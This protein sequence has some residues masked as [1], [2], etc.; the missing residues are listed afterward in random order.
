MDS[1]AIGQLE[2]VVAKIFRR[3][4]VVLVG[5]RPVE[6]YFLTFIGDCIDAFLVP[7]QR[8]KIAFVVIATE[9]VIKIGKDFAFESLNIGLLRKLLA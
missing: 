1:A 5:V 4:D 2:G 8:E 3:F 9:E 6:L 7:A